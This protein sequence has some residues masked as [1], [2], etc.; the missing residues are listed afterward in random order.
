MWTHAF[1]NRM[2]SVLELFNYELNKKRPYRNSNQLL[3]FVCFDL[4]CGG[5]IEEEGNKDGGES[6]TG[7]TPW[8][9]VNEKGVWLSHPLSILPRISMDLPTKYNVHRN[10]QWPNYRTGICYPYKTVS[11]LKLILS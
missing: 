8:L 3:G 2:T 10:Y 1:G 9:D 4:F 7:H 11:L 6:I 5:A